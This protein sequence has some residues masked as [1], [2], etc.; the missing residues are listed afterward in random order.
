[1]Q[2]SSEMK[3]DNCLTEHFN[4]IQQFS[5]IISKWKCTGNLGRLI[6]KNGIKWNLAITSEFAS[7]LLPTPPKKGVWRSEKKSAVE[8]LKNHNWSRPFIWK[9]EFIIKNYLLSDKKVMKQFW[10]NIVIVFV[11]FKNDS[12]VRFLMIEECPH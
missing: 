8:Y 7:L 1:M 3:C 6:D 4:S 10:D 9:T 2:L 12:V 11:A 5:S